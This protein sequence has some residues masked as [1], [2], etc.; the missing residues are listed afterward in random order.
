LEKSAS[1]PPV[2]KLNAESSQVVVPKQ[3]VVQ[4]ARKAPKRRKEREDKQKFTF[5]EK[6]LNLS[7]KVTHTPS[8]YLANKLSGLRDDILSSNLNL[9]LEGIIS[10]SLFI[11]ILL[12]PV[13]AAVALFLYEAHLTLFILATPL[14]PILPAVLGVA[15]IKVS[16]SSRAQA[17]D[18]ELPY[19]IGYI[20][21]LA[22]GGISPIVTIKRIASAQKLFPAAAKEA[23]RI[24]ADIE[25][26]GLDAISALERAA[27]YCPNKMFSDFIGGYV[28]VLKTGGDAVSYLEAK[29]REI[30]AHR[31]ARV[32]SSSEFIGNM[33]ES[34][35]IA[36]VVMGVG[37][38]ILFAVQNLLNPN[39]GGASPTTTP[40]HIDP[41][42]IIL[43][44]GLFVP[45][46]S[47]V[48]I[49]VIGSAQIKEPFSY[50]FQFYVFMASLPIAAV[51]FF[52]NFGLPVY[53]QLA[54]GLALTSTPA[55][56]V[57][58]TYTRNRKSVEAKLPNF[59]RDISEIRKTGLAPEKTIEQL[60]N[61][62]YG[63]L[64]SHIKLISTQLSWGTPIRT[65]LQNFSA[66]V[67]SWLTRAMTFLLLE[68]VD[69]G[70]GSPKMFITL[71]DF[72][73]KNAQLEKERRSMVRP[74]IIIPYIGAV[75]IVVTT[76]MMIYFVSSPSLSFPGSAAFLPSP[77]V[78]NQARN[79]LLTA[80]IFQAWIMGLVAGKMGEGSMADGFKHA[81][82]ITIVG[83]ITILTSSLL[84]GSISP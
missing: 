25:V 8:K 68:V 72:M 50:D 84:I 35:I 3:K 69:V 41:T 48:F 70:G 67:K 34:Y 36:T 1:S 74:Y 82:I 13:A 75:M 51:A 27:K 20:T 54:I 47:M 32:R 37:L 71:A 58:M 78:I 14:I 83:T 2:K 15:M 57:N 65:V 17:L 10:V 46:I 31:E 11:S 30:F 53:L 23:R 24:L 42:M 63:G 43:F 12:A 77:A 6:F 18:N 59:L 81:T 44:S 26:F 22:G 21:V 73:E 52:V 62:N 9:S 79:I 38:M 33:A 49:I 76:A 66:K 55:M 64:S 56:I 80:A 28:S 19:L 4:K 61:R 16:M 5:F 29:L 45:V 7:L 60:A 40:Q 39:G